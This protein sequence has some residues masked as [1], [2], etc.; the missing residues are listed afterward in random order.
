MYRDGN[1]TQCLPW[2]MSV[3]WLRALIHVVPKG[4]TGN[5]LGRYCIGNFAIDMYCALLR[6]RQDK[7]A[8]LCWQSI[9]LDYHNIIKR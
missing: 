6:K 1:I 3:E 9:F 5:K 4:G 2:T 8:K 7:F